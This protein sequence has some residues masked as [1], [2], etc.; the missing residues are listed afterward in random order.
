MDLPGRFGEGQG[1]SGSLNETAWSLGGPASRARVEQGPGRNE[2]GCGVLGE[3]LTSAASGTGCG[4]SLLLPLFHTGHRYFSFSYHHHQRPLDI[5]WAP[6]TPLGT[7]S[8][9]AFPITFCRTS[10]VVS[11]PGS[12]SVSLE[13][14][15]VSSVYRWLSITTVEALTSR[16]QA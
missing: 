12:C 15:S 10:L 5:A 13:Y 8:S 7:V 2:R 11:N 4:L 14:Q 9:L 16:P 6:R 1:R 3:L